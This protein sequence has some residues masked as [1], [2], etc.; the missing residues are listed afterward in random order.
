MQNDLAMNLKNKVEN[1]PVQVI[2][3][4]EEENSPLTF[5]KNTCISQKLKHDS[6]NPVNQLTQL[7]YEKLHKLLKAEACSPIYPCN[8]SNE[9]NFYPSPS[10]P[11]PPQQ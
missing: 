3:F 7:K 5:K 10:P 11:P 6:K 8:I 9:T 2:Y 1:F 4:L